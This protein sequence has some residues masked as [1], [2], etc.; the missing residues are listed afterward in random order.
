[1]SL[2]IGA[3]TAPSIQANQITIQAP[4]ATGGTAPYA[5]QLHRSTVSGFSPGG[6]NAIGPNQTGIADTIAPAAVVDS[7]LTPGTRYYYV[8]TVVDSAGSPATANSAQL[9]VDSIA[10]VPN[11]NQFAQAPFLG[12]TDLY[13]NFNTIGVQ[14]DPA[15]TGTLVGGQ[16]VKWSTNPGKVPLVVPVT[17]AA[18]KG[19]GFVNYSPK[20]PSFVPGSFLSI[21]LAGNVIYLYAALAVSRGNLLTSLPSGVAGG[22]NG[23]VIPTNSGSIPVVGQALDT[24][25]IGSLFRVMVLNGSLL[26]G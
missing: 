23:G 14:F 6:G 5:Y 2:A 8:M 13:L 4:A 7:G 1:M 24:A 12:M 20:D 19:C 9:T 25:A 15:G 11:Q 18:D 22:C 3:L 16:A 26:V 21:S 17:A 10:S